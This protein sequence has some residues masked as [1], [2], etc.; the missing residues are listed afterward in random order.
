MNSGYVEVPYSDL[1]EDMQWWRQMPPAYEGEVAAN[2]RWIVQPEGMA[3]F[4]TDF[5]KD[6]TRE[7]RFTEPGLYRLYGISSLYGPEPVMSQVLT[8]LV[9]K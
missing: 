2:L 1:S 9:L 5:R 7:I 6:F 8:I 3:R 4:N